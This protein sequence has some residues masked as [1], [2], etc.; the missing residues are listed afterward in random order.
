MLGTQQAVPV[1]R[2]SSRRVNKAGETVEYESG[3]LTVWLTRGVDGFSG[4]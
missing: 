4:G 2:T 3:L 1:A